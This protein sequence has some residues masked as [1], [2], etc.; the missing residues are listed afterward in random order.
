MQPSIFL[1]AIDLRRIDKIAASGETPFFKVANAVRFDPH[2]TAEGLKEIY[3]LARG[4]SAFPSLAE[5]PD[6]RKPE[7]FADG[8]RTAEGL[9][10]FAR[11][12][13]R[14]DRHQ[15]LGTQ[16]RH[17]R[18]RLDVVTNAISNH[19]LVAFQNDRVSFRWRDYAVATR[20]RS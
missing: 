20:K 17:P 5:N 7:P 2:E 4:H 15:R 3:L 10:L 18:R 12:S 1:A 14:E 19:R 6:R 8:R 11:Q 13:P 9:S 16:A